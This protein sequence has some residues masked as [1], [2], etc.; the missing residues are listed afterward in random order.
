MIFIGVMFNLYKILKS[1]KLPFF[2]MVYSAVL[3]KSLSQIFSFLSLSLIRICVTTSQSQVRRFG[4]DRS[5]DVPLPFFS[6]SDLTK[7]PPG[8]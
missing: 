3:Y 1:I 6:H 8:L 7:I 4:L 5:R 2:K